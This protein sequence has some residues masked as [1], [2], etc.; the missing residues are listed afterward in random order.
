MRFI[1]PLLLCG[2]SLA[3]GCPVTGAEP[4]RPSSMIRKYQ[5]TERTPFGKALGVLVS[6]IEKSDMPTRS[7]KLAGLYK[8]LE[9]AQ[10]KAVKSELEDAY[11]RLIRPRPAHARRLRDIHTQL[12]GIASEGIRPFSYLVGVQQ[13]HATA[14]IRPLHKG[15]PSQLAANQIMTD[16]KSDVIKLAPEKKH[17]KRMGID[18]AGIDSL[19]QC[20]SRPVY[21]KVLDLPYRVCFF[22]A[23]GQHFSRSK[24]GLTKDETDAV[25]REFYDF[26]VHL[27]KTYNDSGKTFMVG[28]WEGD[29][30]LGAKE[31]GKGKSCGA[32]NIRGMIDWYNARARAIADAKEATKH[33]NVRIHAYIE[34]NHVSIAL[35]NKVDRIVNAVLPYIMADY[36]SISSYDIQG[37]GKWQKPR[38]VA[39]LRQI[40]FPKL[41]YVESMLPPRDI[42][43][44]RVLIGEIGFPLAHLK[45][46]RAARETEQARLA[47]I[48]AQVNLEWGVPFWLWWAV[49]HN[50]GTDKAGFKGFGIVDQTNGHR[51]VLYSQM[52][53]YF[54]WAQAFAASY[55]NRHQKLP[56]DPDFRP[57]AIEQIRSQLKSLYK[58]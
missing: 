35:E 7:E 6:L 17:L 40:L 48:N 25:Y 9:P 37:L 16:M 4:K 51:T 36:V 22:W 12:V 21:R 20:I 19:T 43:G 2:L 3:L 28:N 15:V 33:T 55:Q 1:I 39:R 34:L 46:D 14:K 10:Q 23:H 44:K 53:A 11:H 31:V 26:T 56:A 32:T 47:L 13:P 5:T 58:R 18:P 27:L 41:D 38:T 8:T 42:P 45:G 52:E 24:D 29:W 49:H 54:H 30:L 57:A 50:E